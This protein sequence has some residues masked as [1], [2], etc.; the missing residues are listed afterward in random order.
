MCTAIPILL[1]ELPYVVAAY[2]T[3][4]YYVRE[5]GAEDPSIAFKCDSARDFDEGGQ[6]RISE[7]DIFMSKW[8]P[9]LMLNNWLLFSI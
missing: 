3:N 5:F 8:H 4:G 1:L 9:N 7:S 2:S 6:E